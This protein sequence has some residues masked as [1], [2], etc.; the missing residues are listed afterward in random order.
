[1]TGLA[2][3]TPANATEA[4]AH[5][6]AL[7]VSTTLACDVPLPVSCQAN[8]DELDAS[9]WDAFRVSPACFILDSIASQRHVISKLICKLSRQTIGGLLTSRTTLQRAAR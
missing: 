5:E 6:F 8:D 4:C 7:T 9:Q 3:G 1:M 2:S